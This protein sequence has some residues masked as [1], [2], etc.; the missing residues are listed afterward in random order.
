MDRELEMEV[1]C[2]GC[3][4]VRVRVGRVR[5]SIDLPL[6]SKAWIFWEI[7]VEA[8]W[9]TRDFLVATRIGHEGRISFE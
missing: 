2:G 8:G 3:T 5:E 6:P 9:Q 4:G 7:F 1:Q